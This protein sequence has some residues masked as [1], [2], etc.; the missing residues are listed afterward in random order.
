MGN[1]KKNFLISG[2]PGIGKTTLVK[3]LA[4]RLSPYNPQGFYTEEILQD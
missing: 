4:A 2:L 1:L 3:K